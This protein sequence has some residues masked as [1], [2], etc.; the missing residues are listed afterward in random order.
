MYP[1]LSSSIYKNTPSTTQQ[2][3][4]EGQTFK[5]TGA[6]VRAVHTPGHSHDHMCFIL[7]EENVMFTGDAILGHGTAAVEHLNTWMG[8]LR[9]MESHNC[10]KGYPAHGI[11]IENLRTKIAGE[12]AQKLRRERQVMKVLHEKKLAEVASAGRRK[13]SVT[14]RELVTAMHGDGVDQG[15]REM[16][17][18]PFMEEVLRK[19]AEDGKVAF[20]MRMRVKRWFSIDMT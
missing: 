1:E 3:I 18:E 2:P 14:V 10:S 9:I 6:T 11:I 16:A 12:L 8:T 15:V 4:I 5:V 13:G 20:E 7:E 19:L 17:L